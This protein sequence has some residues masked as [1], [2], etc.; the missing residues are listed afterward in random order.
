MT[1]TDELI[2]QLAA[3]PWPETRPALQLATA[4]G[5]G[6][7]VALTG[8]VLAF[9]SP[10]S[11]VALTGPTP[12]ALKLGYTLAL[13]LITGASALAAGRP[14]QRI[15]PRLVLTA[16]P[17]LVIV[18]ATIIELQSTPSY[19]WADLLFGSTS[20]ECITAIA[21]AGIPVFASLVLA[22]RALAPTRLSLAGF[23]AGLCA[24]ATGSMA[25]ALYC[26]ETSAA[27]LLVSYTPG[28]LIPALAG[29]LAGPRLLRW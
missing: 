11:A 27:F 6:W 12:F 21:I 20:F 26:R 23:L 2:N 25:Y 17:V 9:G 15:G 4:I 29:A 16:L 8:L 1:P 3:R 7:A 24:G 13:A 18:T 14:G 19:S 28:I 22:F 10:L 5:A